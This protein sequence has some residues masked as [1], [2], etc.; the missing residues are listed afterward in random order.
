LSESDAAESRAA[1]PSVFLSYA[2]EDR[3][4]ARLLRDA[5]PGYGLEVWYDESELG[6]GDAW[7]QKIRR[8]IRDCDFFM[9]LV[10]AQTER[11]SEGYFRREWRLAVER[12]LDMAD[13]HLYLLPIVIDDTD[14][15]SARVPEKFLS[16]QWL[17]VPGGQPTQALE[18]MCRR[19]ARGTPTA[20]ERSAKSRTGER[21]ANAAATATA[22]VFPVEEPGQKVRFWVE[23]AGWFGRSAWLQ[24]QRLPRWVRI[25]AYVWLCFILVSRCDSS[26][27]RRPDVPVPARVTSNP[28]APGSAVPEP[29]TPDADTADD[30]PD[31][32]EA[33]ALKGAK[34]AKLKAIARQ[35]QGAHDAHDVAKLGAA[36]AREF[37]ADDD[38]AVP[39]AVSPLLA[40]AFTGPPD[41]RTAAKLADAAF[42]MT[43]GMVEIG[44]QGQV[45]LAKEPLVAPDLDAAVARGKRSHA[46]YVLFGT[47]RT[48][49]VQTDAA[50]Q[51]AAH[52]QQSRVLDVTIAKV[53][54]GSVF[55]SK[56]Y[57]AAGADPAKIAADINDSLP[58]LAV[59]RD[60]AAPAAGAATP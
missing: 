39:A 2:S 55:W 33:A 48:G 25:V 36:I 58:P 13:D 10:S 41:D 8:Q 35:Y 24:F 54:D 17:K 34:L 4:A 16:V 6:G 45:E 53:A 60:P 11:R 56:S 50:Q 15:A 26:S 38:S 12:T 37:G 47:V 57:P 29:A 59:T 3:Q 18:A 7:D 22:P 52:A 14:Q 32:T 28:V 44:H 9:P 40:I 5:L 42:A 43:Y 30:S 46:T 51:R 21:T 49:P 23:V 19:I 31:D 1:R 20:A 27:H